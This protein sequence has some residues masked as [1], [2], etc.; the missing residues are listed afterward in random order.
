MSPPPVLTAPW[1]GSRW[2]AFTY[3]TAVEAWMPITQRRRRWT[4]SRARQTRRA[5]A[6]SDGGQGEPVQPAGEALADGEHR[7]QLGVGGGAGLGGRGQHIGD[8]DQ[9]AVRVGDRAVRHSID[10]L[11]LMFER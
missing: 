3:F 1:A 5:A 2:A 11:E 6:G 9:E 8:L 4:S 10:L 7:Q